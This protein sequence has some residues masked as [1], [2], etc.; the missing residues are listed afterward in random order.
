MV[1][2]GTPILDL[3]GGTVVRRFDG[4]VVHRCYLDP[5]RLILFC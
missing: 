5:K 4:G 3:L 1:V 2:R